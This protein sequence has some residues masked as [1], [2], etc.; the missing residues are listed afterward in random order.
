MIGA[1]TARNCEEP[2]L[3]RHS[4]AWVGG[5]IEEQPSWRI[6]REKERIVQIARL[7]ECLRF[8][9]PPLVDP[10]SRLNPVKGKDYTILLPM[11]RNSEIAGDPWRTSPVKQT[12]WRSVVLHCAHDPAHGRERHD[13]VLCEMRK[14]ESDK[15]PNRRILQ[16]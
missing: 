5:L 4:W 16:P 3:R 12:R 2:L 15:V 11:S 10:R 9:E 1:Q 13:F 14:G 6:L 8:G 7:V